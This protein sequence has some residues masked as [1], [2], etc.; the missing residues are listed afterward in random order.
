VQHYLI[1]AFGESMFLMRLP[2]VVGF[3]VGCLALACL[4]RRYMPALF[5]AS[6]FFLPYATMIRWRAMDARPYG[7][8]FGF[9]ALVLLCW[10]RM[11]QE[12]RYRNFWRISFVLSL[13]ALNSTHFYSIM[14]LLPLGLGEIARWL[15]KR[16]ID[17]ATIACAALGT[18]PFVFWLPILVSVSREYMSGFHYVFPSRTCTRCTIHLYSTCPSWVR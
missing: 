15:Q 2:A 4:A 12:G 13:A 6:V 8:M 5:A 14:V 7:L 9:T 16:R 11:G 1:R 17:W 10:D 18:V 3:T